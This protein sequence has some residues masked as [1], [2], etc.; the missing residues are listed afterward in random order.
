MKLKFK[1]KRFVYNLLLGVFWTGIALDSILELEK[2]RWT[3]YI[4]LA[5]GI[6]YLAK[7]LYEFRYQYI[8]VKNGMLQRSG[9]FHFHKK[10]YLKEVN[11]IMEKNGTY[12]LRTDKTVFKIDTDLIDTASLLQLHALLKDLN[13]PADKNPFI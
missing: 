9:L 4:V 13:L 2:I 1:K 5:L 12:Y 11:A 3:K 10:I 8:I 6:S 7:F